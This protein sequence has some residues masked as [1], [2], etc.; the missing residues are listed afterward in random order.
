MLAEHL[1]QPQSQKR[2]VSKDTKNQIYLVKKI[3]KGI[4]GYCASRNRTKYYEK[5]IRD[6][7]QVPIVK[8]SYQNLLI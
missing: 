6:I 4:Q 1:E 8:N 7:V 5:N 3:V 2:F